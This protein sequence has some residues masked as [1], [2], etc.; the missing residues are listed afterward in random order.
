MR[1]LLHL[2][3]R[4]VAFAFHLGAAGTCLL[5]ASSL[6][7]NL[8]PEAILLGDIVRHSVQEKLLGDLPAL[9]GRD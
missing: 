8:R 7:R 6:P 5:D 4:R 2:A 1:V 9:R 3:A